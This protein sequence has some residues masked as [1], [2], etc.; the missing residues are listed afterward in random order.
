MKRRNYTLQGYR[1]R[2]PSVLLRGKDCTY[3]IHIYR[4]PGYN[5]PFTPKQF[6]AAPTEQVSLSTFSNKNMSDTI[7]QLLLF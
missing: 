2:K 4:I 7:R 5:A 3:M 1:N 6:E